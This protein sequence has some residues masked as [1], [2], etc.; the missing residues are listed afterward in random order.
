[1]KVALITGGSRGIGAATAKAFAREKYT[2]LI[3]WHKNKVAAESLRTELLDCGCDV[4]L[5]KADVSDTREVAEMFDWVAKFFKRL[6]VLVNNAGVALSALCQNVTDD[7]YNRVMDINAKGTFLCCQHAIPF[8][9]RQG[10][11]AIVNVS[12]IWGV[13]G[14]SCESV[15]SM[16][17]HAIVGLTKS[18]S[19]ELAFCGVRVNCV[20]PP[21]VMTDMCANLSKNE[22]E[23]F[24][25]EN[26]TSVLL[27]EDV[28][29][30][31]VR[32][33]TGRDSGVIL[34]ER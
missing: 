33:A 27:P 7:Q 19:E 28:A 23:E 16:S 22:I 21:I 34:Q 5:Y 25:R 15:Y 10:G 13:S 31:I 17:K 20:C 8:F 32:L 11:G 9:L 12:S 6:D 30:D 3:N 4:H 24:C 2:V 29:R 14:A 1:M 18:L 26:G